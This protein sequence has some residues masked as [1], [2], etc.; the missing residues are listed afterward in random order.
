[1]IHE[2]IVKLII[3]TLLNF[4]NL[5]YNTTFFRGG[6]VQ[7]R[8][9]A[10]LPDWLEEYINFIADKYDISVSEAIRSQICL[11]IISLVTEVYPDYETEF[12]AKNIYQSV[13][14]FDSDKIDR[15][16]FLKLLSKTYFEARKAVEFRLKKEREPKKPSK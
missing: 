12:T 3:V 16:K 4:K 6:K 8:I 14:Q 11:A 2:S 13:N 10:V 15:E 5:C 7:K 9:Q 1:M